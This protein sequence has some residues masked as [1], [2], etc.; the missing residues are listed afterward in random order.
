MDV[1]IDRLT[2]IED[3][4]DITI[5]YAVESG[6][7]AWGHYN[8][9]SDYDI[10]F[11]YKHNNIEDYLTIN[12]QQDVIES[13]D[14]LY[15]IVGWDIKKA[16]QL[17]YKSNPNLREWIISPIKY[18][19]MSEDIFE[20]LPE[21][22]YSVLKHHYCSLT[23]RHYRKY[24]KHNDDINIKFYKKLLYTVRCILS[25]MILDEKRMPPMNLEKLIIENNLDCELE[26]KI[27]RL[28]DAYSTMDINKISDND[29]Y[30]IIEWIVF[31]LDYME[32]N[33]DEK[34]IVKDIESYNERFRDIIMCNDF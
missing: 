16:L 1:I 14:G 34:K 2:Q 29:V 6:S 20:G 19:P 22:E 4:E 10:R 23:K 13:N 7:R 33:L 30:F 9:D 8:A 25:W 12:K 24:I 32:E 5:L 21:F 31:W 3:K 15:D 18:V 26:S 27:L 11:I 17:H 28:K